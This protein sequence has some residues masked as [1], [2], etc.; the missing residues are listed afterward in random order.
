MYFAPKRTI[1]CMKE[2]ALWVR[3]YLLTLQYAV[4][5]FVWHF[6]LQEMKFWCILPYSSM[7]CACCNPR[8]LLLLTMPWNFVF[9]VVFAIRDQLYLT[10]DSGF[11]RLCV[12]PIGMTWCQTVFPHGFEAKISSPSPRKK[13]CVLEKVLHNCFFTIMHF[14][15]WLA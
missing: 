13:I 4:N 9:V 12:F 2:L 3:F 8:M 1:S 14:C 11:V 5:H 10:P 15:A 6:F 7:L